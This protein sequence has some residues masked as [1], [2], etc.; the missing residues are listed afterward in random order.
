ME[1][2]RIAG[3]AVDRCTEETKFEVGSWLEAEFLAMN[4]WLRGERLAELPNYARWASQE[5]VPV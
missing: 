2:K 1:R 3:P 4:E 5:Y